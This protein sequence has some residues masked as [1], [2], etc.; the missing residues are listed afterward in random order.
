MGAP[1]GD[2]GVDDLHGDHRAGDGPDPGA[3]HHAALRRQPDQPAGDRPQDR[4][5]CQPIDQLLKLITSMKQIE[6]ELIEAN[7]KKQETTTTYLWR[8]RR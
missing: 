2:G 1:H 4:A 6:L 3:P 5:H 8:R 7:K